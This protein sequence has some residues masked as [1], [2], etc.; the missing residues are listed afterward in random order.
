MKNTIKKLSL[1]V[2]LSSALTLVSC[3][4]SLRI[5][6]GM[7]ADTPD[8][9]VP[10]EKTED[11]IDSFIFFGE[12][13]TYHLKS[14]EVLSG[15]KDTKQVWAPMSGTVNLDSTTAALKIVFPETGEEITIGE[16][17]KKAQPQ[18][19][20]LTF[21]LNGATYKIKKGEEYFR[22]CYLALIN[23]IRESSPSTEIYLQSCFPIARSMDMSA[24]TVDARTLNEYI[25]TVNSWTARLASDERLYYVDSAPCL[26]DNDGFLM[27]EYDGG[28]GFHL[29]RTAYE[30][31]LE[32]IKVNRPTEDN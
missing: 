22:A 6:D 12:S 17:L 20:M 9:S 10:T 28:D 18:R 8:A 15:G 31:I 29:N 21:G 1:T 4:D 16:A 32:Y 11:Y 30:K 19:I 2:A 24:Y 25:D 13:T 7:G 23:K 5:L 14:R 3:K 26:K 27:K